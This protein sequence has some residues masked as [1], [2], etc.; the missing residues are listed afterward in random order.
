MQKQ[1]VD[2]VVGHDVACTSAKEV[3]P[4]ITL[5]ASEKPG[6]SSIA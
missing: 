4:S 5:Q 3:K 1:H 6:D 2:H